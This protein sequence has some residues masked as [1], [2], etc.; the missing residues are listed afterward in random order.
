MRKSLL[1]TAL[2]LAL[3]ANAM[4]A[5]TA[6]PAA[7]P[8]PP[9][10]PKIL[11]IDRA[12]IL[13][14]SKVGQDITRQMQAF[15]AQAKNDMAGQSKALQAEGQALQQQIAILSG[16]AKQ[17]K[18][19]AFQAKEQGLQAT[20]QRREAAIQYTLFKAQ[21]TVSQTL[22]PIVQTIMQQRGANMLLDKT[23]VVA[24]TNGAQFDITQQ[25]ID[26]LNQKMPSLKLT[27]ENPPA[28]P[29]QAP[30]APAK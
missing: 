28:A 7:S 24:A 5:G 18:I 30:A 10:A 14:F 9:P 22:G 26:S 27:L 23:A 21:Q 25:S 19:D 6:P 2:L 3:S 1:F 29:S 16:D 4:A 11:V 20:A 12:A 15:A 17:K 8:G 13:Q